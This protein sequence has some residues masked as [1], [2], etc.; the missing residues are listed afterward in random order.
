MEFVGLEV[1]I[2]KMGDSLTVEV[3][4]FF[5]VVVIVESLG[6]GF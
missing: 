6:R 2:E 4:R 5:G 1:I 3:F